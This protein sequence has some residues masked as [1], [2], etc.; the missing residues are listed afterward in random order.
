MQ[1]VLVG[2]PN[3]GKSSL[4]QA[5]SSGVPE[6]CDY[7]FTTRTIHMGHFFVN[8]KRHQA[9][10][11]PC[12]SWHPA[13]GHACRAVEPPSVG[14]VGAGMC[15]SPAVMHGGLGSSRCPWCQKALG[16]VTPSAAADTAGWALTRLT[17][18]L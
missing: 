8:G 11:R 16:R 9:R 6:I 7:P 3:V 14:A 15:M 10:C 5:L 2:A 12:A 1:V 4:V 13:G 18:A 17:T